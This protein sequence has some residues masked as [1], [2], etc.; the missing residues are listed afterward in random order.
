[1]EDGN[2]VGK[3]ENAHMSFTPVKI[4]PKDISNRM[5]FTRVDNIIS[6]GINI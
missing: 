4:I 3:R 5:H 2:S 6:K 1:M